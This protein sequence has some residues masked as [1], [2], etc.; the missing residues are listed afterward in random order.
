MPAPPRAPCLDCHRSTREQGAACRRCAER[1]CRS[2]VAND[3]GPAGQTGVRPVAAATMYRYVATMSVMG[4]GMMVGGTACAT[5]QTTGSRPMITCTPAS[6]AYRLTVLAVR[7]LM[8]PESA[9]VEYQVD[10]PN[11]GVLN[12]TIMQDATPQ[13]PGKL[14]LSLHTNDRG[15]GKRYQWVVR[16]TSSAGAPVQPPVYRTSETRA[17]FTA[18]LW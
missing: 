4:T 5:P 6:G 1:L 2:V 10:P 3:A 14:M 13:S 15:T 7:K 11:G 8:Q 16:F 17:P 18:S 12:V 9:T